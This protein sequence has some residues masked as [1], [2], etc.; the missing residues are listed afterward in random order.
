MVNPLAD[1]EAT[2]HAPLP[3]LCFYCRDSIVELPYISW[4]GTTDVFLHPACA[5]ELSLRLLRD[6]HQVECRF[7]KTVK[8]L[9]APPPVDSD[10]SRLQLHLV[11]SK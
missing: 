2:C 7:D 8:L 10:G 6:V 11:D 1:G 4:I 9:S 5:I 3:Q